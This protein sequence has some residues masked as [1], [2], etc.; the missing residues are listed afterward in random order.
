MFYFQRSYKVTMV[1]EKS[2]L[3]SKP[4]QIDFVT[5]ID[6]PKYI[7]LVSIERYT[8]TVSWTDPEAVDDV[9]KFRYSSNDPLCHTGMNSTQKKNLIILFKVGISKK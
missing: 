2:G 9:L 5:R 6:P 1:V 7:E 8:G 3:E 4:K